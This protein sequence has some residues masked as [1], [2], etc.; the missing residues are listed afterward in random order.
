MDRLTDELKIGTF[1]SLKDKHLAQI[2]AFKDYDTFFAVSVAINKLKDYEDIG[3][4]EEL[5]ALKAENEQLKARL[6]E[7]KGE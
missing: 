4:P 7:L 6:K 5:D 1:A 2:G 3:T